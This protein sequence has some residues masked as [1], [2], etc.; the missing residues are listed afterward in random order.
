MFAIDPVSSA[1]Y[2]IF[3]MRTDYKPEMAP[4]RGGNRIHWLSLAFVLLSSGA[5]IAVSGSGNGSVHEDRIAV[6]IPVP[7]Q[8]GGSPLLLE[9][10][11]PGE[12]EAGAAITVQVRPGD[13]LATI[14]RRNGFSARELHRV[15]AGTRHSA[16]LARL[17]PGDL[18]HF[19]RAT[20][21][22]LSALEFELD[23][24][25]T[26]RVA[27]N[28]DGFGERIIEHPIER[29]ITHAQGVIHS[30]LFL[31][32][33]EAGLSDNL[34]MRL[35]SIFGWDI[36]FVYDIRAGDRFSMIYEEV[37]RDGEKIR[38]GDILAAEFINRNTSYRAVRF[39]DEQDDAEYFTPDGYAMRKAFLRAPLEYSRISS[40]FNPNRRHPV[41]NTIRAHRGTDYAAPSGTPVRAAG[42]GRVVRRGRDGGYGNRVIIQ[43]GG[44]IT[45]LYAHLSNYRRGVTHG[46]R[47][48]QG[49]VIG[50]VG[51]TGLANG[52]HLH[53]EFRVNGVHRN[54]V[55]VDL[56][57]AEPLPERYREAFHA[58]ARPLLAHLA[59]LSEH[60]LRFASLTSN[61]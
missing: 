43:H 3:N 26:L 13:S 33:R 4:R 52:P 35:T 38:D 27:H 14:F 6:K 17:Q 56:P 50:Y 57:D 8:Q 24:G 55:T 53:Y 20:D 61:R 39:V 1:G 28:G 30:S 34:T 18:L 36:D 47:V 60:D 2:F 51:M 58:Y 42:D 45:T 31:A 37:Y 19:E 44:N 46:T 16:R 22:T 54:P 11:E 15:L 29:R 59:V 25:Q 32:A 23:E 5:L 49:Q 7:A 40:R 9:E 12:G 41:L 10:A 48:R 21:E